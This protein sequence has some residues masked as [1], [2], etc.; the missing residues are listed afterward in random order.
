MLTYLSKSGCQAKSLLTKKVCLDFS[1][2]LS[3]NW[4]NHKCICCAHVSIHVH[5]VTLLS[6]VFVEDGGERTWGC[7]FQTPPENGGLGGFY[8]IHNFIGIM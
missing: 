2:L 8:F 1:S 4:D 7:L 3:I 5:G 6:C